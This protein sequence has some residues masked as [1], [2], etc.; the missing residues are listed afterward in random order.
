MTS[1]GDTIRMHQI[2]QTDLCELE[3]ILPELTERL[4][5]MVNT[6]SNQDNRI[7]TQVRVIQRIITN[8]RWNYQPHTKTEIIEC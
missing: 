3:R 1:E 5:S 8:V 6:A 7:C 4:C 2:S